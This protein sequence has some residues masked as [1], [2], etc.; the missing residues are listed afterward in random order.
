MLA[1]LIAVALDQR[2][3]LLASLVVADGASERV[4]HD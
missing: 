2:F 4:G 3:V 1:R